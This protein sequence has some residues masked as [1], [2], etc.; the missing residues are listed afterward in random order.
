MAT[1]YSPTGNFLFPIDEILPGGTRANA[2][3]ES[4]LINRFPHKF[5]FC[6]TKGIG[7]WGPLF[8]VSLCIFILL[9]IR[10]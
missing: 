9:F 4:V 1:T 7:L 10:S 8:I 6:K 2:I 5:S 3:P